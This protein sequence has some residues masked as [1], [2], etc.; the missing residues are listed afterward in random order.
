[1]IDPV[2]RNLNR[3]LTITTVVGILFATAWLFYSPVIEADVV[4]QDD[5]TRDLISSGYH[6]FTAHGR[7]FNEGLSILMSG[8]SPSPIDY[9]SL[10]QLVGLVSVVTAVLLLLRYKL[11]FTVRSVF[12][13]LPLVANPFLLHNI[14]YQYDSLGMLL[15]Y[16]SAILAFVMYKKSLVRVALSALLIFI[17]LGLYQA[18]GNVF[19]MLIALEFIAN[20]VRHRVTVSE[21]FKLILN[22]ATTYASAT[23]VYIATTSFVFPVTSEGA[24]I[25]LSVSGVS[26]NITNLMDLLGDFFQT[27]VLVITSLNIGLSLSVLIYY[28]LKNNH[29]LGRIA[30]II[31][32]LVA[33]ISTLL[34]PMVLSQ[35][36]LIFPRSV[37]TVVLF[38]LLPGVT[39]LLFRKKYPLFQIATSVLIGITLVQSIILSHT[40]GAFLKNQSDYRDLLLSSAYGSIQDNGLSG[41]FYITGTSDTSIV[42]EKSTIKYPIL[43]RF[44]GSSSA[45]NTPSWSERI[46]RNNGV[47]TKID[48][49]RDYTV[50]KAK[51]CDQESL[52]PIV[53]SRNYLIL[54]VPNSDGTPVEYVIFF[55]DGQDKHYCD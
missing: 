24:T 34:G 8:F 26:D 33:L 3:T 4:F 44:W 35:D 42:G 37:P 19:L 23:L 13:A 38:C 31:L 32:G 14:S 48:W 21:S 28:S 2:I 11:D 54:A 18:M 53:E 46:M 27:P 6:S 41:V 51:I 36:A 45:L 10:G 50:P 9:G 52:N 7:F 1:M 5:S 30:I 29:A 43:G 47:N 12:V 49:V 17:S 15:G 40:Y 22:Q 55:R 25:K 20:I 16:S 39:M